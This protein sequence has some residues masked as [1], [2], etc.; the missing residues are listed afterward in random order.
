M[1]TVDGHQSSGRTTPTDELE[2]THVGAE[3]SAG[4]VSCAPGDSVVALA[5]RMAIYRTHAVV[6]AGM[7]DTGAGD[8]D[9]RWGLI[10]HEEVVRA[11]AEDRYDDPA[12]ELAAGK[13][14]ICG[15]HESMLTAA[16]RMQAGGVD[17][18]VVVDG[19]DPIGVI[20][21][22]DVMRAASR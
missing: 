18:L 10:S 8:D 1:S 6:I 16:R 11:L 9:L 7:W 14:V 17:H 19:D 13:A 21:T 5:T 4:V 2:Q 22:L 12:A 3:M 20:S 15:P